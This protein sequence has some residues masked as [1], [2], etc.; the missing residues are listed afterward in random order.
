MAA[1]LALLRARA[2][3]LVLVAAA[4]VAAAAFVPHLPREHQVDLGLDDAVAVT[5]VDVAWLQKGDNGDVK[6]GEL[7]RTG[8]WRFPAGTAPRSL[9]TSVSL[10]DGRYELD[11]T[12]ER[13]DARQAFHR[14]ITL[15]AAE[16]VTVPLR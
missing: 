1:P 12:V 8:E 6:D 7:V 11:V 16:Q 3:P 15:D 2:V 14:A 10:P 9:H 13:G 5:A 4:A